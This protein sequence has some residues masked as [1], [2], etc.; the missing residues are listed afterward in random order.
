VTGDVD[1]SLFK[2][3]AKGS[4]KIELSN[5]KSTVKH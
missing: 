1:S 3:G 5:L 2:I 4:K